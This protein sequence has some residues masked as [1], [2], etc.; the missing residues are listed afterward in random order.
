MS[1]SSNT[2]PTEPVHYVSPARADELDR[3]D[4]ERTYLPSNGYRVPVIHIQNQY[5]Q[6]DEYIENLKHGPT[7]PDAN[8]SVFVKSLH[9]Y[10]YGLFV[11]K[12]GVMTRWIT[13][14][15]RMPE[16][17]WDT[18]KRF[19]ET[20]ALADEHVEELFRIVNEYY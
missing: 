18:M 4:A 10:Q 6:T 16:H 12:L 8:Q 7:Y 15:E 13:R 11:C 5:A 20:S 19:T 14:P 2:H 1:N 9:R 17:E 3:R